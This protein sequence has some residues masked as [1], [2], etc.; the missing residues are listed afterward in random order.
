[1]LIGHLHIL[2]GEKSIQ[3]LWRLFK[4]NCLFVIELYIFIYSGYKFLICVLCK[5]ILLYLWVAFLFIEDIL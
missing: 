2:F 4:L 3:L 5:K 1:M